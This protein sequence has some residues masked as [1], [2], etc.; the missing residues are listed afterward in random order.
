MHKPAAAPVD[1]TTNSGIRQSSFFGV[2]FVVPYYVW[3]VSGEAAERPLTEFAGC[4]PCHSR[5]APIPPTEGLLPGD[6]GQQKFVLIKQLTHY[7]RDGI[8]AASYLAR[9]SPVEP[10]ELG[11]G[12]Q[13]VTEA[14]CG[15]LEIPQGYP[16]L[17]LSNPVIR[18]L[19]S[20]RPLT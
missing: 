3:V 13:D 12:R 20:L 17:S 18:S 14:S 5:R 1:T 4:I 15:D 10:Q 9:L 16:L 8:F 2:C 6:Y 11:Q 7:L 19:H